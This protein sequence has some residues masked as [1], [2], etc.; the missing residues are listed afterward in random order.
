MGWHDWLRSTPSQDSL[1]REL[2][3]LA[4]QHGRTD[5]TYDPAQ[6]VLRPTQGGGQIDVAGIH[7]EYITT[8]SQQ[9]PTLLEKYLP[10]L[11]DTATR[12][13]V[14]ERKDSSEPW[15]ELLL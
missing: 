14:G 15:C 9:R 12:R 13:A 10:L 2:L 8:R 1:A 11:V 7:R 4:S 6:C 3:R 5:W